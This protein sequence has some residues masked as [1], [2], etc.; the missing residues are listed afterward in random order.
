MSIFNH[1]FEPDENFKYYA[2]ANP[3]VCS[4]CG[5]VIQEYVYYFYQKRKPGRDTTV[6]ENYYC[7]LSDY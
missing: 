6:V 1:N 4:E 3:I 5:K 2:W 7:C